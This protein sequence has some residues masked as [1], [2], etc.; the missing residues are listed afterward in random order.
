MSPWTSP[1]ASA[2]PGTTP[3]T[4]GFAHP[5]PVVVGLRRARLRWRPIRGRVGFLRVW[6]RAS[7]VR[8]ARDSPELVHGVFGRGFAARRDFLRAR[9]PVASGPVWR[10]VLPWGL[11]AGAFGH[12]SWRGEGFGAGSRRS[13]AASRRGVVRGL[14]PGGFPGWFGV[15][16][17]S[18][19]RWSRGGL[20]GWFRGGARFRRGLVLGPQGFLH[21]LASPQPCPSRVGSSARQ[22]LHR[23]WFPARQ[24]FASELV[25]GEARCLRGGGDSL[26]GLVRGGFGAVLRRG[27]ASLGRAVSWRARFPSGLVCGGS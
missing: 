13:A 16:R 10:A 19:V 3:L 25:P 12:G 5:L 24:G 2:A 11:G 8:G 9:R 14:G 23:S 4:S 26:G 17:D 15:D 20:M 18:I 1:S 21:G 6:R 7:K 22:G 27:S